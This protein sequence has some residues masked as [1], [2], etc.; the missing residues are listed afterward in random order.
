M[1]KAHKHQQLIYMCF[2]DFKKVFDTISHDKL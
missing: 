1:H 2:V